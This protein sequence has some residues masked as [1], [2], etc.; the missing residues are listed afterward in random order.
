MAEARLRLGDILVQA[1]V[2]SEEQLNEALSRQRQDG[3][4]LTLGQILMKLKFISEEDL[5]KTLSQQLQIPFGSYDEGELQPTQTIDELSARI[6]ED[7][8][9]KNEILPLHCEAGAIA[10]VMSDPLDI[11]LMDNI[12]MVSNCNNLQCIIATKTDINAAINAFYGE[13]NLLDRVVEDTYEVRADVADDVNETVSLDNAAES[14]EAGPVIQMTDLLLS[15]AVKAKASDIHIEPFRDMVAIRY[16]VDGKLMHM[17]PPA[18]AMAL[19]II[20]RIKVLSKMDI[21]ERRLPQDGGFSANILNRMIDFRVSS[22]PTLHGEKIVMRILDRANVNVSL[23]SLGFEP[24]ILAKFNEAIHKPHGLILMTGPTGSGKTT[25]LYSA[26][27]TLKTPEK[28]I[29]T[30]EDPVEY[31]I[32]GIN[33]VEAKSEI[34]LTFS[35]G[36]RAFLRQDPDVILVGEIRDSETA[37]ICIRAA[38]TGHLVF[39]TLHTNDAPTAI[40]RLLDIGIEPFFVSASLQM[41]VAQRLLRRLCPECKV[42]STLSKHALP[43]DFA[44]FEG[45]IYEAKG[46][47]KCRNSG[48]SGRLAI[49]EILFGSKKLEELIARNA[50]TP[51]IRA[52]AKA[53]GMVSLQESGYRKVMAGMT[54][55]EEVASLTV[56]DE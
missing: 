4:K 32:D 33:Q 1:A 22:I 3:S 43:P 10:I 55:I 17:P 46:C 51:E 41:I 27:T 16:R 45:D 14:A 8:A 42:V 50:P 29:V 34:G 48:Y 5:A 56:A 37:Q 28:N 52:A 30:I 11:V 39:S 9:R 12:R 54:S 6:P 23:D 26:L 38:L 35:T 31:Q 7:F 13:G 53:N 2:I 19:P 36:L 20:S 21:G 40:N 15:Q 44:D 47:D 18:K 49:H 25:T 24:D